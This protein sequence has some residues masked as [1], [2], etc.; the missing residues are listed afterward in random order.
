MVKVISHISKNLNYLH[1]SISN[2]KNG[3]LETSIYLDSED[4]L[5]ELA[6]ALDRMRQ[7]YYKSIKR[8]NKWRK[9]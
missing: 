4:E 9:Q 7:S 1:K 5:G 8:L 3:D 6:L 2:I